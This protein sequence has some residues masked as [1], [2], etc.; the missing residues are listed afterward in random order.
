[1]RRLGRKWELL[2]FVVAVVVVVEKRTKGRERES[3][4]QDSL[5][6]EGGGYSSERVT[7]TRR[8]ITRSSASEDGKTL[9]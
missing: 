3:V 6:G 7:L 5:S 9:E 2:I 8:E 1:M 4:S